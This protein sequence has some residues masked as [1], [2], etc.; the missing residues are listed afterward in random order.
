MIHWQIKVLDPSSQKIR[1]LAG[2]GTAGFKD[3]AAYGAQ[4]SHNSPSTRSVVS[5]PGVML[6]FYRPTAMP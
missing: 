6:D 5:V 2:T 1:T 4:V 3:G